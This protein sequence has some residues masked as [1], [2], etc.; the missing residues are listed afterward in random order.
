VGLFKFARVCVYILLTCTTVE[1]MMFEHHKMVEHMLIEQKK[2]DCRVA[3]P[4][5]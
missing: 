1:L 2:V 5:Q 3:A 4:K